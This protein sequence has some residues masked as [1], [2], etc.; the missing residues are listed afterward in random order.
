MLK[1]LLLFEEV[2]HTLDG[3]SN[4][5]STVNI[6]DAVALQKFL[7]GTGNLTNWKNGDLCQDGKIDVFDMVEIRKLII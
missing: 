1:L 5:D 7:L 2:T 3:D 6:S 4:G